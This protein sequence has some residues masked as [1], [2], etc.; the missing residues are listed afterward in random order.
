MVPLG[1]SSSFWVVPVSTLDGGQAS[2]EYT[3]QRWSASLLS[4]RFLMASALSLV[5]CVL[6]T[7]V[8]CCGVS[9]IFLLPWFYIHYTVFCIFTSNY[10]KFISNPCSSD[11]FY[12]LVYCLVPSFYY[13]K[14]FSF[15]CWKFLQA[16]VSIFFV[17]FTCLCSGT[18]PPSFSDRISLCQ[19]G[20][21]QTRERSICL[22]SA[23]IKAV[24]HP[25]WLY[26]FWTCCL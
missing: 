20:W 11:V 7:W 15:G 26:S 6:I 13:W 1:R 18:P 2:G 17:S 16:D 22:L 9:Q 12:Y 4:E 10:I 23:T 3:P 14:H 21:P 24:H 8:M 19:L 5:I 25:A